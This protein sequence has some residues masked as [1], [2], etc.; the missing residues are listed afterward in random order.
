MRADVS[1]HEPKQPVDEETP[2]AFTME[3]LNRDQPGA[4]LP[5]VWSP[6]WNSNQSLHKFQAEVGGALEGRHRRRA[7]AAAGAGAGDTPGTGNGDQPAIPGAGAGTLATGAAA[8][9][10]RQRRT[11][12]PQPRP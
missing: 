7:P 5:Y 2:L 4:L 10:F 11:Q 8:A 3:G 1:V 6:G 12:R 9:N